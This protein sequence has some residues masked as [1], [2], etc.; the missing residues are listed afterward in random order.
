[1]AKTEADKAKNKEAALLKK[2]AHRTRYNELSTAEKKAEEAFMACPENHR[3]QEAKRAED[4]AIKARERA[5]SAQRAKIV[6][7]Q[8][9]LKKL[10][11]EHNLAIVELRNARNKALMERNHSLQKQLAEVADQFPD[12]RDTNAKFSSALWTPP[13]GYIEQFAIDNADA[14]AAKKAKRE[15]AKRAAKGA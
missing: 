7:L 9:E 10:E 3:Y 4:E 14:L 12:M 5:V 2:A 1:M 11:A 15:K 13:S 6:L 8:D